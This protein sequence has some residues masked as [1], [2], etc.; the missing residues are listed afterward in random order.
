MAFKPKGAI[1]GGYY[2]GGGKA[3]GAGGGMGTSIPVGNAPIKQ[4]PVTEMYNLYNKGVERQAKD[5]DRIMG[6]YGDIY[7]RS[8]NPLDASRQFDKVTYDKS[9]DTIA[10]LKELGELS[11]TGGLDAA[12]QQNLRA[13]GVSPIRSMYQ[14]AQRDLNRNRRLQGGY[15]PNYG[16]VTAKMTRDQSSMIA[17]QMDKVNANIAQ[18]VQSGRLSAAPN[19]ASA[20]QQ[21]SE[22][23]HGIAKFNAQGQWEAKLNRTRDQLG[24]AQGATNLYGTTPALANLYGSQAMDTAKFQEASKQQKN[25]NKTRALGALYG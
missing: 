22:L 8:L 18:M 14:T 21:E 10:A 16:A 7:S 1:F 17:D 13:R 6:M 2:A 19:Y 9:P 25:A 4:D 15:S 5:Y 3:A 24:A 20:A 12:A 23:K 11:R